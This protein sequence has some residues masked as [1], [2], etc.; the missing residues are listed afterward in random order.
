[1]N[2]KIGLPAVFIT[3]IIVAN[4]T[5]AKLAYFEIPLLGGVAIPAGFI[6]FGVAFLAS[7]LMVE[8]H[9]R[10]FATTV[11]N[12][13]VSCLILGYGLIYLAIALP[14]APFYQAHAAYAT[15]LGAS[16]NIILASIV[17]LL[18]SQHIDVNLFAEIKQRTGNNHRWIRNLMSTS[19]S[20]AVDTALFITLAFTFFPALT[21]GDILWG[22]ALATT[23]LGQYVAKVVVA[24][25]DTPFF[26]LATTLNRRTAS[27]ANPTSTDI[28][29]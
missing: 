16:S 17:T 18:L 7:D 12:W 8:V 6:A 26:Y 22:T 11:V 5:A 10:E 19:I 3:A 13:T 28:Q 24:A 20:Q 29:T 23:I 1:M 14:T 15:T 4:V 27:S 9:G 25:L 2:T 21:S